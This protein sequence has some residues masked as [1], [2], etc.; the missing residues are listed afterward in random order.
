MKMPTEIKIFTEVSRMFCCS[1]CGATSED[2]YDMREVDV[3]TPEA[4]MLCDYCVATMEN[5]GELTRCECCGNLFSSKYLKIN[6]INAAQEI[7]PIC[8]EVWCS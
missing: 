2:D 1:N 3:N 4:R 7:C 8:G 5:S 6:P